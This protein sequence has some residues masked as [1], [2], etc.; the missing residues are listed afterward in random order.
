MKSNGSEGNQSSL[1][2]KEVNARTHREFFD[3][4]DVL[5]DLHPSRLC[6]TTAICPYVRF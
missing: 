5:C 1:R 6:F 2:N 3:T 4:V